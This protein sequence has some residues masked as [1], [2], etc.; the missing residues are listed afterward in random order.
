MNTTNLTARDREWRRN[1]E[2]ARAAQGHPED[3]PETPRGGRLR[4]LARLLTDAVS[5]PAAAPLA[6]HVPARVRH[7]GE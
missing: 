3:E 7:D 2:Q 5:R 1:A 6:G 4:R